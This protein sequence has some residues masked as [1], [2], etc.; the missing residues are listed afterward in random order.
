MRLWLAI[1]CFWKVLFWRKLPERVFPLAPAPPKPAHLPGP[2]TGAVAKAT[3]RPL[4]QA[5]LVEAGA[6]TMLSL[7]Q[8]EGR[9]L[10][11]LMEPIDQYDDAQVG[12]A[13]RA[14]H[15]GCRKALAEHAPLEPVLAAKEEER[16]EVPAGFDP[17]A[18]TLVGN[19]VGK[20]PFE[21][22]LRHHGWRAKKIKLPKIQ[23]G[24]PSP[25]VAPAEVEL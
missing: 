18:I 14:I 20:P 22:T 6:R 10:D 13:V 17:Q 19:V 7:L 8:R 4:E 25:V 12:A 1:V 16:V 15:A 24:T 11:F 21:G 5:Q 2:K 23:D 9:L 3:A